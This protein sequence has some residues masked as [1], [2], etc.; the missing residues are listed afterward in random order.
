M[1]RVK[2]DA[3]PPR[4]LLLLHLGA[5]NVRIPGFKNVDI[6]PLPGIDFVTPVDDLGMFIDSCVDLI[7][8]ASVLEHFHRGDT[9]R[10]L[11]EWY[12]VLK[13]GGLLRV[14]VP[15]FGANV[16]LYQETHNLGLILGCLCG[17]QDYPENFHYMCFDFTYLTT[18]LYEVGF[19]NVRRYDW[20]KTI[21]K[22][23][24]DHSQAYYPHMDKENGMLMSLNVEADKR[25]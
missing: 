24:D 22:D 25:G 11:R 1:A 2:V 21:H 7:Y 13:P 8:S 18:L 3:T 6:R 9:Q 10:V 19:R 23:Y 12:R 5:G 16:K 17:G 4:K 20:R 15:D 14:S